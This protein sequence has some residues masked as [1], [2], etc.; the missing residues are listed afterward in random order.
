LRR[1][2][3]DSLRRAATACHLMVFMMTESE[4]IIRL[5]EIVAGDQEMGR[6]V[7]AAMRH[8][9]IMN[10]TFIMY[11]RDDAIAG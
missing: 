5:H 11:K 1:K 8:F 10:I 7:C 4:P 9:G 6:K 3:S 2:S